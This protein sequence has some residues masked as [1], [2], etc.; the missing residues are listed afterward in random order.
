MEP[1]QGTATAYVPGYI[2]RGKIPTH[3][4]LWTDMET[5]AGVNVR[6]MAEESE[7]DEMT[8]RGN[9]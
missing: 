9:K 5:G 4:R 6:V 2:F 8:A 1:N 3:M 7:I